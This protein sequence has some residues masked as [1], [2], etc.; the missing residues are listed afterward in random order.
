MSKDEKKICPMMSYHRVNYQ[1]IEC[2]GMC[3]WYDHQR[4]KC[5][6]FSIMKHVELMTEVCDGS[7]TLFVREC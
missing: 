4:E 3:A 7:R 1:D 6:I 5:C 2:N